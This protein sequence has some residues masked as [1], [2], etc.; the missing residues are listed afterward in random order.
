MPNHKKCPGCGGELA[1]FRQG[2]REWWVRCR[3]CVWSVGPC[4]SYESAIRNW[5]NRAYQD[6]TLQSANVKLE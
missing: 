2:R 5:N 6:G 4:E 1:V 3:I